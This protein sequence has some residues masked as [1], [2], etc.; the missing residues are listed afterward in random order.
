M[1]ELFVGLCLGIV[2]TWIFYLAKPEV[3]YTKIKIRYLEKFSE[4]YFLLKKISGSTKNQYKKS[5]QELIDYI[6]G[7]N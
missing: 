4:I 7:S 3:E 2:F 5:A 6:N 1:I